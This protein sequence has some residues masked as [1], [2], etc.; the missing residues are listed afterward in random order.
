MQAAQRTVKKYKNRRYKKSLPS[1]CASSSLECKDKTVSVNNNTISMYNIH[2]SYVRIHIMCR[3]VHVWVLIQVYYRQVSRIIEVVFTSCCH[4]HYCRNKKKTRTLWQLCCMP[5]W[6][7]WKMSMV[8]RYETIR[9]IRT[10]KAV[11]CQ[12]ALPKNTADSY[13]LSSYE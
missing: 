2:G 10:Q 4:Q 8:Q 6:K 13:H 5:E 11:L 12:Q 1:T 7:L 9:W 3:T